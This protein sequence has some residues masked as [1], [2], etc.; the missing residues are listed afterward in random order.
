MAASQSMIACAE[1]AM[2]F[3]V[4]QCGGVPIP[5]LFSAPTDTR[6]EWKARYNGFLHN[7][8]LELER[9]RQARSASQ[10]S[11]TGRRRINNLL[12]AREQHRNQVA[13]LLAPLKLEDIDW[14][15]D[16][17]DLLHSKLPKSQGLSSYT[18]NIFR[19]WAWDNGENEALLDAIDSVLIPEQREAL[20]AVLTLGAGA[21]RLPFDLHRRYAPAL[22]VVLDFNPLLIHIACQVIHG[23]PV[24]LYEFPLAPVNAASCAVLQECQ[25]PAH[26]SNDD[27]YFVFADALN[28]P[29]A[30]SSFDT[31]LTPWLIDVV[32]Q[33]LRTFVPRINRLLPRGGLWINTGSLA[34]FHRDESWCYSEEEVF[35]LIEGNGFEVVAAER[36]AVPYLQSPHSAFGRVEKILSFSAR[37]VRNVDVSAPQAYLPKWILD[38]SRPVPPTTETAVASS[39]HL[40]TAQVLAAIDGK[41][42]INQIGRLIARQYGLGKRETV[43]AVKRILIDAWEESATAAVDVDL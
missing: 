31:V 15:A 3:P 23:I 42:T 36:Q 4:F 1:C 11:N 21:C 33:N 32:P 20:G 29:F 9:L 12:H 26:L 43:H 19:D 13:R 8:S 37:K 17:A 6:L 30:P 35:E 27:F 16:V 7:N 22:S 34:F 25:A 14:P 2:Q 28:P 5:W 10:S 38:T 24:S 41:R 40:L 18:S 39:H